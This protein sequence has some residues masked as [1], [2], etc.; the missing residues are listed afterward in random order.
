ML[1]PESS[2]EGASVL[3][4]D[5][6]ALTAQAGAIARQAGI[7][8]DMGL[9]VFLSGEQKPPFARDESVLIDPNGNVAWTYEK[10]H[11]APGERG[12]IALGDGRLPILDSAYGRLSNAICFDLDFPATIRR[13]GVSGSTSSWVR[14]MTGRRSTPLTPR[15]PCSVRSKTASPW[16]DR[17]AAV[18]PWRSITRAACWPRQTT[19]LPIDRRW[20]RSCRC[21]ASA[22]CT[23]GPAIGLPC[24]PWPG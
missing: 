22:R 4:E 18:S 6:P 9:A 20:W 17:R 15:R 13:A 3:Q 10:T 12:L 21:A 1:W 7:Y 8:L 19:L 5:E 23:R 11:P 14:R 16:R 2:S 24:C